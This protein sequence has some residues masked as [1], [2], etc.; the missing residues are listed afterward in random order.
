MKSLLSLLLLAL[1]LVACLEESD[2][3][4][5]N[6]TENN[7]TQNNQNNNTTPDPKISPVLSAE[8]VSGHLGN[9]LDCPEQGYH[10]GAR[11]AEPGGAGLWEGDCA[12][13][14]CGILNCEGAQ[15][16]F[17]LKNEGRVEAQNLRITSIELFNTDGL[18]V[19]DLPLESVQAVETGEP[20]ANVGGDSQGMFYM[21]FKGPA[22]P[23]ELLEAQ[24]GQW[25]RAG[26]L[27][28][29]LKADNHAEFTLETPNIYV[30]DNIAT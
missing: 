2:D 29:K 20:L 23:Y 19:A 10:A 9:Y 17:T 25:G 13:D 24:D 11:S 8:F 28:I 27:L 26:I 22:Q 16:T 18:K 7:Q 1:P 21:F 12:E 6:L 4:N 5:W 15:V 14:G 30:L 3:S